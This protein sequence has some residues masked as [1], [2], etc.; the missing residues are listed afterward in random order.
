L[1]DP[2]R[3]SHALRELQKSY[4]EK[5]QY[6][7]ANVPIDRRSHSSITVAAD[8]A[9]IDAA[10]RMITDFRRALARFLDDGGHK[11]T[12]YTLSIGLFPLT[13]V[14]VERRTPCAN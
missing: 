14:E 9:K 3:T 4:L 6:A 2:R 12:V 7:L 10:R 1:G 8:S 11:D 5:S 13:P